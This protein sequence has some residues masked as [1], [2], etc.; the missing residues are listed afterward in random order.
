S[1][2]LC[3]TEVKYRTSARYGDPAEAVTAKKQQTL[4][5][6]AKVYLAFHPESRTGG[7]WA[8]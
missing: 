8:A 4:R 2:T 6:C 7:S 3:F 5:L 1:H